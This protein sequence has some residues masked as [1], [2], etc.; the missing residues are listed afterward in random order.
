MD[1]KYKDIQG[2]LTSQRRR[3]TIEFV[4]YVKLQC[5]ITK[6]LLHPFVEYFTINFMCS[7]QESLY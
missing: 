4:T 5:N 2:I 3:D 7:H 6:I 1:R